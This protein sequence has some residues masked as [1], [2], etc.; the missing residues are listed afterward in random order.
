MPQI[1]Y[2]LINFNSSISFLGLKDNHYVDRVTLWG[3]LGQT[4]K[5]MDIVS[6]HP[7]HSLPPLKTVGM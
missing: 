4:L 2:Y 7:I 1:R 3:I 6:T 5:Y